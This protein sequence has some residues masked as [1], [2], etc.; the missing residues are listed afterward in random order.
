[1]RRSATALVAVLAVALS[2]APAAHADLEQLKAACVGKEVADA[3]GYRY[4]FCDDGIPPAG[5]RDPNPGAEAAVAVP[6]AYA[7]IEGLPPLDPAAAS[8][9]PGSAGGFVALDVDVSLPD[10]ETHPRPASGYPLVAIMH[11]CCSGS[12]RSWE[13]E[14][15]DDRGEKW[16]YNNAWWAA[17]GYVVLTWTARGFVNGQDRGST[18]ETHIDSHL[19]EINDFQHLVGQ[20]VDDP[21]FGVDPERIVATGGSYG[22]GFTWQAL[23]DPVWR[24]PGGTDIELVAAAPKYGW[25]DLLASLT[26]TG[27]HFYDE[28]P[29]PATDGS[30]SGVGPDEKIGIPIRTI[31]QAL[32]LSGDTGAP[33][34]PPNNSHTTFPPDVREAYTCTAT[35]YPVETNPLCASARN[36]VLPDF[37]NYSSAF[38]RN[39]FFERLATDERLRVPVF[40][41]GTLTDPLFPPIEHRRMAER[42][43]ATAPGY[44]IQEYYGDYNHFVQNKAKEWGDLCGDDHHVCKVSD[45]PEGDVERT[46]PTRVRRGVTSRLNAFIDHYARPGANPDER[47]PRFDVTAS[48]QVC[49]PTASDAFPADEPGARFTADTF[50]ALTPGRMTLEWV[51]DTQVVTSDAEPNTHAKQADPVV[52]TAANGS[53]CPVHTDEAGP[54]VAVYESE[55]LERDATMLGGSVIQVGYTPTGDLD[56][57]QLN[58]RLYDVLPDGTLVMADRGPRRIDPRRDGTESVT[59]QI[60]G[61]G[62]R[63]EKGHRIRLELAADDDPYLHMSNSPFSLAL[64]SV[65]MEIPVRETAWGIDTTVAA[66]DTTPPRVRLRAKRTRKGRL[67]VRIRC[68]EA[69]QGVLRVRARRVGERERVRLRG[70]GR[71]QI[72]L[73]LDRRA[74]GAKRVKLRLKVAD[75]SGNVTRVK[76][77]VRLR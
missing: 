69:C 57:L 10:P 75:R 43:K 50:D 54:G 74:S 16:R 26:P 29:M 44:P 42:L 68:S 9:V 48:L 40:S 60:H 67:L 17:R 25:T 47:K 2:A 14:L 19:Y 20:L 58:A 56:A 63:F 73:R 64:H 3:P 53:R 49:P 41:A 18:G 36:G 70:P 46:P 1:M 30:D 71:R 31:V 28:G 27:R 62:W 51:G 52:N 8:R 59:F 38:Y 23:T 11:G 45:H 22:G 72:R 12:K 65:R 33:T 55:P 13:S 34:P 21:F 15:F 6:A 32:F 4:R 35:T 77:R 66:S 5:G 61:N 37:F 24:S 76:K 39:G 7:G